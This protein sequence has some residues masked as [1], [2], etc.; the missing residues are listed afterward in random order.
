MTA[1]RTRTAILYL[2]VLVF[3]AAWLGAIA[4]APLLLARGSRAASLVYAVFSPLCHQDTD[5]CFRLADF[6][7]AVCARC[8]GVY[9]GFFLGLLIWPFAGRPA[10]PRLPS[11]RAFVAATL[12]IAL[13]GAGNALG[14]WA[15]PPGLRFAVGAVWGILLPF[16]GMAGLAALFAPGREKK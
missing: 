9:L 11:A 2:V 13:D 15:S 12:P 10:R 4:A 14:L 6:P 5:R 7:L 8:T 1:P 3:S 16:Y